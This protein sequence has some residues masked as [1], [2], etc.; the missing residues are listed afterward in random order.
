MKKF[1]IVI[2]V[3]LSSS[4]YSGTIIQL[5]N[6]HGQLDKDSIV[7]S[8]KIENDLPYYGKLEIYRNGISIFE[9]ENE[10]L[11]LEG[12]SGTIFKEQSKDDSYYYVFTINDRPSPNKFLVIKTSIDT[13][14]VFGTTDNNTAEIFNDIDYDGKFEIG[15]YTDWGGQYEVFEIDNGFPRDIAIEKHMLSIINN[16]ESKAGITSKS[17]ANK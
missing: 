15:G 16:K 12:F 8:K 14:F 3:L 13:T 5:S 4:V 7:L 6:D 9:Y 2:S 1:L 17:S 10:H 11:E